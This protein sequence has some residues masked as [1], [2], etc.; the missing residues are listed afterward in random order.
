MLDVVHAVS[1]EFVTTGVPSVLV[2]APSELLGIKDAGCGWPPVF[3]A[4]GA[5]AADAAAG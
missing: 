2:K 5:R 4:E 3:G 1:P